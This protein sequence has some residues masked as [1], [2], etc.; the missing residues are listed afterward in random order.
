LALYKTKS[1]KYTLL[2]FIRG[3]KI[4]DFEAKLSKGKTLIQSGDVTQSLC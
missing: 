2:L 1:E 4:A 3:I